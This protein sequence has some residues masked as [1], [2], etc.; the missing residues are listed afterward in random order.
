MGRLPSKFVVADIG[1]INAQIVQCVVARGESPRVVG[2]WSAEIPESVET[3]DLTALGNW[4]ASILRDAEIA[5]NIPLVFLLPRNAIGLKRF[6]L[7]TVDDAD[8]P[9]MV[10]LRL[11]GQL[12]FSIEDAIV[13]FLP[14]ATIMNNDDKSE[15]SVADG[16]S[17]QIMATA[18]RQPCVER[19]LAI[20][21]SAQRKVALITLRT[22]CAAALLNCHVG[23]IGSAD[24]VLLL[25]IRDHQTVE[26]SVV[27]KGEVL[28]S[29]SAD[30]FAREN[31]ESA[32]I[33]IEHE[34]PAESMIAEADAEAHRI[35]IEVSRSWMSYRL[36]DQAPEI[37]GVVVLGHS[38]LRDKVAAVV[39][40]NLHAPA[41][42][43]QP[44]PIQLDAAVDHES[45]WAL[46]GVA[47]LA[48]TGAQRLDYLNPR[49][50]PDVRTQNRIRLL[51]GVAAMFLVGLLGWQYADIQ[52]S[53]LRTRQR[54]LQDELAELRPRR[55]EY[56][57]RKL[58]F[59]H[60][61]LWQGQSVS[62]LDHLSRIS[63]RL[64]STEEAVLGSYAANLSAPR[65]EW[66]NRKHTWIDST[67]FGIIRFGGAAID[68]S[69]ADSMRL[70]F[71]Q[72]VLY[73]VEPVASDASSSSSKSKYDESFSLRLVTQQGRIHEG[74][75]KQKADESS[76]SSDLKQA[77]DQSI[78][79]DPKISSGGQS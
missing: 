15:S 24:T 66:D 10:R 43:F 34:Q 49:S 52:L 50:A 6:R 23:E 38:P 4:L 41:E 54:M 33:G 18:V 44:D 11:A 29:R 1:T 16:C 68:R 31:N 59:E 73:T 27:S 39:S 9:G 63:E 57:R 40:S 61:E 70:H 19:C 3:S 36:T 8:L 71:V 77:T 62:F 30:L 72:D 42:I 65:V 13:D 47:V 17:T 74:I 14:A 12:P 25:D 75:A 45:N 55:W 5:P 48:A 32:P 58:Q 22:H 21:E 56:E 20:A 7:P 46:A 53:K 79:T 28:F 78:M 69:I 76:P 2:S 60:V 35:A 67:A 64:P 37:E 26:I 51:G